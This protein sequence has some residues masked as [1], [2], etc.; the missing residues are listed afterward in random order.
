MLRKH[1]SKWKYRKLAIL[2]HIP[3]LCKIWSLFSLNLLLDDVLITVV[4][5]VFLSSHLGA[6]PHLPWFLSYLSE[7]F[8]IATPNPLCQCIL[9]TLSCS[10][11]WPLWNFP[12]QKMLVHICTEPENKHFIFTVNSKQVDKVMRST[13][14]NKC[15]RIVK[16][17]WQNS[18]WQ[19]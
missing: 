10:P 3:R 14:K 12:F 16:C 2:V 17:L 19:V 15:K 18:L 1:A 13:C 7:I 11:P 8:H 5:V 9:Y 6:L 4:V